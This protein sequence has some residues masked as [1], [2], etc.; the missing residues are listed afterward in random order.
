MGKHALTYTLTGGAPRFFLSSILLLSFFFTECARKPG[1]V[2]NGSLNGNEVRNLSTDD[3]SVGILYFINIYRRSIGIPP[4]QLNSLESRLAFQ[5]SH[6]M[7]TGKTPFGHE[8]FSSRM[9]TIEKQLGPMRQTA[10]NVAYGMMTAREVVDAWLKSP[11]HR[12]NIEGNFL[13]TGIGCA[14]NNKGMIYYTEI[15]TR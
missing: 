11:V 10:E 8:G 7:A 14:K 4:I 2:K 5:H 3:M 9:K 6:N 1:P 12:K 15:F 13:L